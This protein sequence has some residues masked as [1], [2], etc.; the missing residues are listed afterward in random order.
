MTQKHIWQIVNRRFIAKSIGELSYEQVLQ[1]KL[2][3]E[4]SDSI[5]Q[6]YRLELLSGVIYHFQAWKSAW[7]HLRIKPESIFKEGESVEP[8]AGQF[9]ID[10]QKNLELTDLILGNYL[11]EVQSTLY[12]DVQ[13]YLR[14]VEKN[15]SSLA[16][17]DGDSLQ[18]YL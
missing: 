11:E 4:L 13:L 5:Y 7:D 3:N 8:S 9:F 14:Q 1:P 17:L 2:E 12:S 16:D 15:V 6:S 18:A 10:A